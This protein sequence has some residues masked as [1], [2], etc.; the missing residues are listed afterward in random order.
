[1]FWAEQE[2]GYP[3]LSSFAIDLLVVSASST[4]VEHVFSI[5]GVD[6]INVTWIICGNM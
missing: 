4:P 3:L 5:A 1:M 6:P 2:I